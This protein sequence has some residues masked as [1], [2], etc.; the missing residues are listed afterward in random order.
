[1]GVLIPN[2]RI[3]MDQ[4]W[5]YED[6]VTYEG[7]GLMLIHGCLVKINLAIYNSRYHYFFFK[8]AIS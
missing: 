8:V 3:K 5:I 2:P 1:M 4:H 6:E 7:R